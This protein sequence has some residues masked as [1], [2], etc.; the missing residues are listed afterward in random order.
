M[1]NEP[2]FIKEALQLE[3][4]IVLITGSS[5]GIGQAIAIEAARSGADIVITYN[6]QS[7]SAK[8]VVAEIRRIG[9]Q[10]LLLQIDV[11]LYVMV[12]KIISRTLETFGHIDVLINNAD[13]LQQ[14]PFLEVPD[15]CFL[16]DITKQ[17]F[18]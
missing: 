15:S 8:N 17:R 6:K 12:K 2:T 9:K 7:D 3:N 10:A 18:L 16:F 14:K 5:R 11:S 1:K 4:K 13:I